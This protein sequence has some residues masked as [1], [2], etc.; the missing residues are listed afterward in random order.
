MYPSYG[1]EA[2]NCFYVYI[3]PDPVDMVFSAVIVV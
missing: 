1:I 2:R 3:L